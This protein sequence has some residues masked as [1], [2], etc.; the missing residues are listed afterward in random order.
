[1]HFV[2][3]LI[4][5]VILIELN[6]TNGSICTVHSS[7]EIKTTKTPQST[8]ITPS[9]PEALSLSQTP[10]IPISRP[11]HIS[12]PPPISPSAQ[13]SSS[14]SPNSITVPTIALPNWNPVYS[15][16]PINNQ[17]NV[18]L[19][20]CNETFNSFT[21]DNCKSLLYFN[22]PTCG[23]LLCYFNQRTGKCDGQCK[24]IIL[25]T[26][27]SRVEKPNKDSDCICGSSV[28]SFTLDGIP[29]CDTSNCFGNPCVFAYVSLN[30]Q[31]DNTLYGFCYNEKVNLI[32]NLSFRI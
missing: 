20:V 29:E 15:R 11:P 22:K 10:P 9:T 8:E 7:T 28:A 21:Q 17:C 14:K 16:V 4:G 25:E 2:I 12:P 31:K 32:Q 30:R 24:N 5:I 27:V 6:I 23:G 1:M 3:Y 19:S 18:D 26:C 13:Q